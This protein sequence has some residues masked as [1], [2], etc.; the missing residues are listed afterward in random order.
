[1]EQQKLLPAISTEILKNLPD[2]LLEN[3][4]LAERAVKTV[5]EII[6]PLKTIDIT[7]V[8]AGTMETHD[9]TLAGL[10]T[11]LKEAYTIMNDGRKHFTQLFDEI[12]SKFTAE[13]NR[14]KEIGQQVKDIR[15]NWQKEKGRRNQIATQEQQKKLEAQQA[16]IDAKT[17]FAKFIIDKFATAAVDAIQRMHKKFYSL[18]AGELDLYASQLKQWSGALDADT[19]NTFLSGMINPK[20][21]VLTGEK[22]QELLNEVIA[23]QKPKLFA[24]W[25]ER[26][27][28]ERNNLAE[29]VPSRKMELERIAND[30]AAAKEAEERIA[31]EQREREEKM[32]QEAASMAEATE[33]AAEVEKLNASFDTADSSKVVDLAKGTSIKCKY[34]AKTHTAWV[35][36]IQSWVTNDMAKMTLDELGKKLSF[37][38]TAC[39]GRLNKGEELKA[40]GLETEEDYSTRATRGKK[41]VAA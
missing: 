22:M 35:A 14:V 26:M 31:Q 21:Q 28:S 16:L 34:V 9:A 39:E 10:Q 12:K 4:G 27:I 18:Q 40:A 17:Y 20:P 6:A 15:D 23:E 41:E 24:E 25:Q 33:T 13:E 2:T 7:K 38:K 8:D 3:S 37:M 19:W 1:M 36:I 29:I 5:S 30:T 32:K 11:R